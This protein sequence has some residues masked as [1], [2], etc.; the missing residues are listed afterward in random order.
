MATQEKIPDSLKK[1][2]VPGNMAHNP[3]GPKKL[4]KK[5]NDHDGETWHDE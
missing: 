5:K 1:W 4:T 3:L 2:K